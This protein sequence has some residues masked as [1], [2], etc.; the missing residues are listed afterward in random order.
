VSSVVVVV[1]VAV[2]VS[3]IAVW[4]NCVLRDVRKNEKKKNRGGNLLPLCIHTNSLTATVVR[5]SEQ[6]SPPVEALRVLRVLS[7]MTRDMPS[8]LLCSTLLRLNSTCVC[9]VVLIQSRGD[10]HPHMYPECKV[11]YTQKEEGKKKDLI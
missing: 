1:V 6:Q 5:P 10:H 9:G 7:S 2:V 8:P 3:V 11:L 4:C